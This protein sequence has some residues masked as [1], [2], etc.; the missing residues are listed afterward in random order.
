MV[1]F[2][3]LPSEKVT[4]CLQGHS[5]QTDDFCWAKQLPAGAGLFQEA[6]YVC[7]V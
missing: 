3:C 4:F 7:Q 1:V 6:P 5:A 2:V